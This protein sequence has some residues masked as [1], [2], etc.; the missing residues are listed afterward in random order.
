MTGKLLA[1]VARFS[2]IKSN[3]QFGELSFHGGFKDG[4]ESLG[5]LVLLLLL[6]NALTRYSIITGYRWLELSSYQKLWLTPTDLLEFV[7][8]YSHES[9]SKSCK[10]RTA[11][12]CHPVARS[13]LVCHAVCSKFE[14]S[15][16]L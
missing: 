13:V 12:R 9:H 16:G 14:D 10:I 6:Y 7:L 8:L 5:K 15:F 4:R 2:V 1:L 3:N 11:C